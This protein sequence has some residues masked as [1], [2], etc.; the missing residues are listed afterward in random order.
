MWIRLNNEYLNLEQIF[1][2]RFGKSWRKDGVTESTADVEGIVNGEVQVLSRYRGRD[3]ESLY[4][5]LQNQC[6][7]ETVPAAVQFDGGET[8]ISTADAG[9]VHDF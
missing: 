1:R 2:I 3:A 9:T 7:Y 4:S 5:I 6:V 8:P